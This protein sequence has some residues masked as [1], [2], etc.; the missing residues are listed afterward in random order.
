MNPKS[1]K[2]ERFATLL[3]TF[4]A[5]DSGATAPE[6]L[7]MIRNLPAFCRQILMPF[8]A[9]ARIHSARCVGVCLALK[10]GKLLDGF[11]LIPFIACSFSQANLETVWRV[12]KERQRI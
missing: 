10:D 4:V 11:I 2:T 8:L 9:A 12:S 1:S 3:A 7:R 5:P 6:V